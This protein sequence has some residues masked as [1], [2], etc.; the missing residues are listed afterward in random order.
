[1]NLEHSISCHYSLR[2]KFLPGFNTGLSLVM[3]DTS[4]KISGSVR[5]LRSGRRVLTEVTNTAP[6]GDH[7]S[8]QG[9]GKKAVSLQSP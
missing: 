1:M 6:V 2:S 4:E 3:G 8:R 9:N 7:Q 5:V